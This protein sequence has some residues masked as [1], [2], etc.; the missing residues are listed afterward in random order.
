[1]TIKNV[2]T[3]LLCLFSAFFVVANLVVGLSSKAEAKQ[4]PSQDK[5]SVMDPKSAICGKIG[6]EGGERK[7][8]TASASLTIG[9]KGSGLQ[10]KV[11]YVCYEPKPESD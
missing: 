5:L 6:C 7:C 11:E 10:V 1:M 3:Y 4:S 8:G 9:Y 2:K